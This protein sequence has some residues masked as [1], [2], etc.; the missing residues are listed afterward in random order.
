[1]DIT[2]KKLEEFIEYTR[3]TCKSFDE[4]IVDFFEDDTL[5]SE[6]FTTDQL[7]IIDQEIMRCD[8][9]GWWVESHEIDEEGNCEDCNE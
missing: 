1:M 7:E 5:D 8:S 9:C 3:G 6:S 4:A 2:D